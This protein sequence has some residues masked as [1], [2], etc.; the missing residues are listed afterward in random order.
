MQ[1]TDHL[2]NQKRFDSIARQ[3]RDIFVAAR[4]IP[5]YDDYFKYNGKMP[6]FSY[7]SIALG[8]EDKAKI[9]INI[10][11][12]IGDSHHMETITIPMQFIDFFDAEEV[13]KF[14]E[15]LRQ[16]ELQAK[17]DQAAAAKKRHEE[18]QRAQLATL[19]KQFPDV[20]VGQNQ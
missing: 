17:A 6:S 15:S 8:K 2:A 16:A 12:W 5:G 14:A 9:A 11:C 7:E 1:F 4:A 18:E 3:I 10:S 20:L 13:K 19:M